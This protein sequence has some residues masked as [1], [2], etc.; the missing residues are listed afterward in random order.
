MSLV[1][2][3]IYTNA[4]SIN[5]ENAQ[6]LLMAAEQFNILGLKWRCSDFLIGQLCPENCIGIGR[7]SRQVHCPKLHENSHAYILH[8]FHKI[9]LTSE[10]FLDLSLTEFEDL[11]TKDNLVVKREEFVFEAIIKWIEHNPNNRRQYI[12]N[13]LPKVGGS[14]AGGKLRSAEAY[15]P[16]NNIW[17]EIASMFSPRSN[18][19]IEVLED[20]LYVIGGFNGFE[21]TF[22]AEYYDRKWYGVHNMNIHRSALD[23]CILPGLPNVRGL[24]R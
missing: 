22:E 4:V 2:Q 6:A 21:T 11:I 1:L 9:A 14:N 13:L 24:C 18:F 8:H 16:A 12:T 19:G 5:S 15:N 20:L 10:E 17:T 3:Y 23:C 7:F